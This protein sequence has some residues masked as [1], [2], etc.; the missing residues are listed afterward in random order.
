MIDTKAVDFSEVPGSVISYIEAPDIWDRLFGD[1]IY[2]ASPSI[3]VMPDGSY[4]ASHD[5]FYG[6][7][8]SKNRYT[9]IFRSTNKGQSWTRQTEIT[10]AFW[11]TL[12]AHNGALY[13]WGYRDGGGDSTGDILIRKSTDYGVTWT[14]PSDANSGLLKDGSYGGTPNTPVVYNG[15]IWIAQS[16]KRVMSAP[17]GAD[18][19][20]ASSW[21]LS[22][23]ANTNDGPLGSE[24]IISEAQVVASPQTGVVLLPKIGENPNSVL[25]RA[26]SATTMVKPGNEDWVSLPGAEKK[27]AAQYDAVSG[28]FYVL[29]NPVLA[30]HEGVTTAALTRTTGALLSSPDLVNWDVE[31][32]FLFTPNIDNG[33]WGEGFQYF[34]FAI[35]DVDEDG[36]S[37]D[38]A[39]VSRTAYRI[40]GEENPPRGH[41]SNLMT[42]HHIDNFRTAAPDQ[43][44]KLEDG[45]VNRYERTGDEPAPL[46]AFALGASFVGAAL[47]SPNGLST[48]SQGD[49][50]V[51]ESGGR[52]LK[53]DNAGNFLELVSGLPSGQSWSTSTR[54]IT[55]PGTDRRAWANQSS[56]RGNWSDPL[57]WL[58]WGRPDTDE[59][60]A[61]F[62]SANSDTAYADINAGEVFTVK[63]L[64]FNSPNRYIIDGG[65]SFKLKAD[66]GRASITVLQGSHWLR[67]TTTLLSDTDLH[68]ADGQRFE[69]REGLDLGGRSLRKTGTGT[70][71]F[72]QALTM[73]G[74]ELVVDGLSP[75]LFST[76]TQG[77]LTLDGDIVF[78]PDGSLALV[79]GAS[80]DLVDGQG[81]F[82]GQQFDNIVLPALG[83]G[84]QWDTSTFYNNG[85]VS[86]EALPP[87]VT[88]VSSDASAGEYGSD[89]QLVFTVSRMGTTSGTL[90]VPLVV[91]GTATPGSDFTGAVSS[92]TLGD[93]EASAT[94]TLTVLADDEAEGDE[95]VTI[96]LGSSSAYTLGFPSSASATIA[97][98]PSQAFYFQHVPSAAAR[99]PNDDP[100]K[101][102]WPNV[103][104]YYMGTQPDDPAS[105][106]VFALET[107]GAG[108][109]VA[110]F[111]RVKGVVDVTGKLLWS[112]DLT[113]WFL[114][115]QSNGS[116]TVNAV[117]NVQSNSGD[118]FETVRVALSLDGESP[119]I[120][121]V[122]LAVES[123]SD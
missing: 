23:T 2:V 42:F 123:D 85:V 91:S 71:D 27:F 44:L 36:Q 19:L 58:Y 79:A 65:G 70:L 108:G 1:E 54:N 55:A 11:S 17:V 109:Y 12:F 80:F 3:T 25:L 102:R 118:A 59:E 29:D 37:D 92:L 94:V 48:D 95:T 62:G 72:D 50:Y 47:S 63:G 121:Y 99:L 13:L 120:L 104:E 57:N 33:S 39:I 113:N 56:T 45:T 96:S 38:L 4:I 122:R 22:N 10:Y 82:N 107:A 81:N 100:D 98:R 112:T 68:V 97:D 90:V 115:G 74:G 43:Y 34:Q 46:G 20:K 24:L 6:S 111:K 53:F 105:R 89:H 67:V 35:D 88:I 73:G 119:P 52:I 93:G 18:L 21:T 86:I 14:N 87:T 49:V 15:R 32:I 8:N 77:Q 7:N 101:D 76:P 31:K 106:G 103:A 5:L 66:S 26:S 28:R 116:L 114:C 78:E 69:F 83:S 51:R 110:E 75:F 61:R 64:H 84:L 9:R 30:V 117:E 40:S 41:D 16:G 60:I